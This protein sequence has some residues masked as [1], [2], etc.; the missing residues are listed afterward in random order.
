MF[1]VRLVSSI[2]WRYPQGDKEFAVVNMPYVPQA[3]NRILFEGEAMTQ[4]LQQ[5]GAVP[6]KFSCMGFF[7]NEEG[8]HFDVATGD[9]I[10]HGHSYVY[11]KPAPAASAKP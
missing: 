6:G 10:V 4:L 9:V 5:Q 3:G 2:A 11:S 7:V 1:K 8:A